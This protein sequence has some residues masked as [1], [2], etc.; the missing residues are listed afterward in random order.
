MADL[1]E[2]AREQAIQTITLNTQTYNQSSLRLYQRFG[3]AE[4]DTVVTAFGRAVTP[5]AGEP[6]V[7]ANRSSGLCTP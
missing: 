1:I 7:F 3:F 2:H 5:S 4:T 6:A